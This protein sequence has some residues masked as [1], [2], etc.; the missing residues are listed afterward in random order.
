MQD[1]CQLL[2]IRPGRLALVR[3]VRLLCG[4]RPLVFARSIVPSSTLRGTTRRLSCLGSRPLADVLFT[5]SSVQREEM[6]FALLRPGHVL[7]ELTTKALE[8]HAPALWGRRSLFRLRRK[9]LLV[10]EMFS[11]GIFNADA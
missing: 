4:V 8:I 5:D 10:S 3:Q 6:E 1:E 7:H 11:P 9:P 2:G